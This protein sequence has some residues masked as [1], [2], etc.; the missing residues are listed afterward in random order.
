MSPGDWWGGTIGG[1]A[2]QEEGRAGT[3]GN[4]NSYHT[5]C[6]FKTYCRASRNVDRERGDISN[7]VISLNKSKSV[8]GLVNVLTMVLR[9]VRWWWWYCCLF[10]PLPVVVPPVVVPPVAVVVPPVTFVAP[11]V[12]LLPLA[13]VVPPGHRR[14]AACRPTSPCHCRAARRNRCA[15]CRCRRAAFCPAASCIVVP[16]VTVAPLAGSRG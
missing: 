4:L 9:L 15:A 14:R 2:R 11:P 6:V 10:L 16:P 7:T 8:S 1:R 12:A 13:I 5:P 3:R